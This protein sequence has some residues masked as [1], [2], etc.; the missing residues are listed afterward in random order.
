[1]NSKMIS[2]RRSLIALFQYFNQNIT[3][4]LTL[5]MESAGHLS[6]QIALTKVSDLNQPVKVKACLQ[7]SLGKVG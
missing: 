6:S 4:T 7:S 1:M 2:K 3:L 5:K